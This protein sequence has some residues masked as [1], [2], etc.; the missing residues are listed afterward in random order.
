MH[1]LSCL[2]VYEATR[3]FLFQSHVLGTA[4]LTEPYGSIREALGLRLSI[5]KDYDLSLCKGLKLLKSEGILIHNNNFV[6]HLLLAN[7]NCLLTILTLVLTSITLEH[8]Q[9]TKG[10]KGSVPHLVE[11]VLSTVIFAEFQH[12]A[13]FFINFVSTPIRRS[14]IL[15]GRKLLWYTVDDA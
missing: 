5:L 7:Q 12:I 13:S 14:H 15:L 9:A 10:Y 6:V 3:Q 11:A 4:M 8:S 1:Y 2:F